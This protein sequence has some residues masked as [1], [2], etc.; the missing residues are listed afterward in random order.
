MKEARLL[1]EGEYPLWD[2][3]V[4]ES[5]QGT[6]F[7]TTRWMQLHDAPFTVHGYFKRDNLLGGIASFNEPMPA[8]PFQGV[9]VEATPDAKYTTI[10]SR[11]NEVAAALTHFLPNEFWNHYTY[12]DMRPFLWRGWKVGIRYTYVVN[13][14]N[15]NELWSN[16]EKNTRYEITSRQ[17]LEMAGNPHLDIFD[18][19]YSQTFTRKGLSRPLNSEFF[20]KLASAI[21]HALYMTT[22]NEAGVLMIRDNKR[23]YYIFGASSG[24]GAS[25]YCLWQ[26]LLSESLVRK[27]VD[28][29][30]CN[31]QKIGLFKR[32]FAGR[33]Q[34]Y[35]GVSK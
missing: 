11:H 30:G 15:M 29:V 4:E 19:L 7:S 12:P 34:C 16:L 18:D 1:T 8:T 24:S 20:R 25:S 5:P 2:K 33:L 6:I 26:A 14:R 27:E 21:D 9:L 35:F 22:D 13:L 32:G 3:F 31:N 10:M 23:S 17:G 28:L